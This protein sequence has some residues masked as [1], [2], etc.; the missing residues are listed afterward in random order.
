M[1]RWLQ[2]PCE[3]KGKRPL[4]PSGVKDASDDP[5]QLER[6]TVQFPGCNWGLATGHRS[7][8]VVVDVDGTEGEKSITA[9]QQQGLLLP[10]TLTVKT[11]DGWHL[12]FEMPPDADIRNSVGKIAPGIDIRSDGGYV[13]IP[14]SVHPRGQPYQTAV[15]KSP[16]PC[17]GTLLARLVQAELPTASPVLSSPRLAATTHELAYAQKAMA[18][19]CGKLAGTTSGRNHALNVAANA[20]GELVS[21]GWIELAVVQQSLWAAATANGYIAK[22]GPAEAQKTLQSGLNAGLAKPRVPLPIVPMQIAIQDLPFPL[23]KVSDNSAVEVID[24]TDITIE[25]IEFLWNGYLPKGKLTLLAGAA[26]TGKS[27]LAFSM[28]AT[29]STGGQW[30][31]GT[32]VCKAGHVLIWSSEDD[33]ADTIVPRLTAMN[34]DLTRIHLITRTRQDGKQL[35]PF[36]PAKDIAAL[37][38]TVREKG[39]IDLLILDPIVSAIEGDMNKSNEVRRGLQAVVD[40]ASNLK[41]AVVGISH[42]AKG[43]SGRNPAERVIG[44]VAFGAFARTVLVAAKDEETNTRVFTRAKSNISLDSGGFNYS[45]NAVPLAKGIVA[46]RIDWGGMLQGSS[47]EILATVE[48]GDD[49]AKSQS[50]SQIAEAKSFLIEE[51]KNGPRKAKDLIDHAKEIAIGEKTLQRARQQLGIRSE[52]QGFQ[53]GYMWSKSLSSHIVGA[54]QPSP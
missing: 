15:Y 12:Y 32:H 27:T 45:I 42:F 30:P 10:D 34:A 24:M 44:S 41:C 8:V 47:R 16:V 7:G 2:F 25:P 21:A 6:W 9:L 38:R 17:P 54:I 18:D 52:K 49:A 19:E 29:V 26:G 28:A 5:S 22:D 43:T 40:F 46:T 39:G 11:G 14:P 33:A 51:L 36:N 1:I 48:E 3:V 50:K 31:D 37:E 23:A 4:T 53:S 20:L 13:I 35:C